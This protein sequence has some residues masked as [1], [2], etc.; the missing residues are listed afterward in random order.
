MPRASLRGSSIG[1]YV[2]YPRE[3]LRFLRDYAADVDD[4]VGNR[5][6]HVEEGVSVDKHQGNIGGDLIHTGEVAPEFLPVHLVHCTGKLLSGEPANEVVGEV[7]QALQERHE[8]AV[9]E[10]R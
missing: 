10:G 6:R 8:V 1:I 3:R 5:S 2:A 9:N 4:L 7:P